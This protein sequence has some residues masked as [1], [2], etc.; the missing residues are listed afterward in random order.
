MENNPIYKSAFRFG[1]DLAS[2]E[3]GDYVAK[4]RGQRINTDSIPGLETNLLAAFLRG[5]VFGVENSVGP[6]KKG[7]ADGDITA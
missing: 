1:S 3:A 2:R 5:V 4:R 6:N 7:G